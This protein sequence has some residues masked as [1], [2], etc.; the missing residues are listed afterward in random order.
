VPISVS[1]EYGYVRVSD[2]LRGSGLKSF[3]YEDVAHGRFLWRS[4]ADSLDG[5][6]L[7]MK[8]FKHGVQVGK[9]RWYRDKPSCENA[10]AR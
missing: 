4:T 1:A 7:E 10:K 2:S 9:A 6:L 3:T 5:E 8:P